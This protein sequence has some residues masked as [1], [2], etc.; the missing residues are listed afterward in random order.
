MST[1]LA[2]CTSNSSLVC[3]THQDGL[4]VLLHGGSGL[5][6]SF[7]TQVIAQVFAKPLYQLTLANL[8]L[9]PKGIEAVLRNAFYYSSLWDCILVLEDVDALFSPAMRGNGSSA[10]SLRTLEDY[11]GVLFLTTR[12]V[13][14]LEEAFTSR[15]HYTIYY[16][17]FDLKKTL[18]IWNEILAL[19]KRNFLA[20]S[21]T[22]LSAGGDVF[23]WCLD[24]REVRNVFQV[25]M[26]LAEYE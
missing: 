10:V 16:P 5:G 24:G 4:F 20:N 12:R 1:N 15:M 13:G 26:S 9:D 18:D 7:T 21:K 19:A 8:E 22:D 14:L 25:A 3:S 6:K 23:Q 11:D 2:N 17:P